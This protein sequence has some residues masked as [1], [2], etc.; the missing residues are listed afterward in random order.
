LTKLT[1]SAYFWKT[2]NMPS[3]NPQNPDNL[4][5]IVENS[6]HRIATTVKL[7][8]E[9]KELGQTEFE[10][11]Y[12]NMPSSSL[13]GACYE[14]YY[15]NYQ[16]YGRTKPFEL[17]NSPLE[18]WT[19]KQ[20][21]V[22]PLELGEYLKVDLE[23]DKTKPE[24]DP[25]RKIVTKISN[26]NLKS[27]Y[28][29]E[30]SFMEDICNYNG[31]NITCYFF[32]I[33]LAKIVINKIVN[34]KLPDC[35]VLK[36]DMN[37]SS[38]YFEQSLILSNCV[39][40]DDANFNFTN[41]AKEVK[42]SD[43]KFKLFSSKQSNYTYSYNVFAFPETTS[44]NFESSVFFDRET[45]FWLFEEKYKNLNFKDVV[46]NYDIKFFGRGGANIIEA[47]FDSV[48]INP[49]S[50][51]IFDKINF[52]ENILLSNINFP[53]ETTFSD[54]KLRDNVKL[55]FL[56]SLFPEN[57]RLE[58]LKK[59]TND[60]ATI[61]FQDTIFSQKIYFSLADDSK[62]NYQNL[63]LNLYHTS[64]GDFVCDD[65]NLSEINLFYSDRNGKITNGNKD[66]KDDVEQ[67]IA[68]RRVFRKILQDLNWGDKADEE[69]A[70]IMDLQLKLDFLENDKTAKLKQFFF[71]LCFGWGVR[72]SNIV[73]TGIILVLFFFFLYV[74][75]RNFPFQMDLSPKYDFGLR[76]ENYQDFFVKRTQIETWFNLLFYL[77]FSIWNSF[78]LA[79]LT[80]NYGFII[81][82]L[83]TV[84]GV[85]GIIYVTVLVAIISRKFMRM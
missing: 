76:Y 69:Y 32:K 5:V 57:L 80:N 55:N 6:L 63:T 28:W 16:K 31:T 48:K 10:R 74:L 66:N 68:E 13:E 30:W 60:K 52:G 43:T 83:S 50:K 9:F 78:L 44:I 25:K 49:Q 12:S 7:Y 17:L 41:F 8:Q 72:I 24:N 34:S 67:A 4:P 27:F 18:G 58:N 11:I 53:K 61:S 15:K 3:E 79:D 2:H 47:T 36:T 62:E 40:E 29:K 64:F 56:R 33:N 65:R 46:F 39:I 26:E 37:A 81:T 14:R 51:F 23:T 75:V 82:L 84:Q 38:H 19:A 54:I 22:V 59:N 20:D 77:R 45:I 35:R 71:S 85:F 1:K 21:G 73:W 42:F 70:R